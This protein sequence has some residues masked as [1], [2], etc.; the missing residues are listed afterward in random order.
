MPKRY[1]AVDGGENERELS[2]PILLARSFGRV[3]P[4]GRP[5]QRPIEQQDEES[6][7]RALDDDGL[8]S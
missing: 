7:A 5:M 6:T 1:A 2:D 3:R 4:G 8:F